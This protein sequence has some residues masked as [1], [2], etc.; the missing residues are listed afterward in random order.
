MADTAG[1]VFSTVAS[2][3]LG[4]TNRVFPSVWL[5]FSL[6]SGGEDLDSLVKS[7]LDQNV[8]ID[9][10]SHPAL[11][12]GKMRGTRATLM[13]IGNSDF[14]RASD[15][16]HACD[17][18]QANLIEVLSSI[19]REQIDFYFL[20]V[21]RMVEEYQISGA[22]QALEMA[23][24]EGHVGYIGICCDGPSMATLGSWQFHDAFETLLVPRNHYDPES[25]DTLAPLARERRVGI[26][27]SRPFNWGFGLP[28]FALPG[29]WRLRNLTQSF[30]GLTLAQAVLADLAEDHP[31]LVGVRNREEVYQAI[32][33]PSLVRPSG[34]PAMLEPFIE[35][36]EDDSQWT[37]LLS[38]PEIGYRMAAQ[39][40]LQ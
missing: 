12:G 32:S 9:I 19:G 21:R 37:E 22:L 29:N 5:S 4:R 6:G 7:V 11:W 24:Q 23:K 17:L 16:S 1:Q 28:F 25:Y 40:R 31:V 36:F 15:E 27:T 30:Y 14:E 20:R 26:I 33:A 18:V 8:P 3:L 34:L 39:R 2:G 10:T 38:S 13:T 35:A